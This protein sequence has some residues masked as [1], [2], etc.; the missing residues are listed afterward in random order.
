MSNSDRARRGSRQLAARLWVGIC[1]CCAGIDCDAQAPQV[2]EGFW[3]KSRGPYG[4]C[5]TD[6]IVGRSR[7]L[8]AREDKQFFLRSSDGGA[9]WERLRLPSSS[10]LSHQLILTAE[11]NL[12]SGSGRGVEMSS[13]R[14]NSWT[15]T[16]I[17]Q[18]V[19]ALASLRDGRLLLVSVGLDNR[20]FRSQDGG[21]TWEPFASLP[22]AR[23]FLGHP[24][25]SLLAATGEGVFRSTDEGR[26][27]LFAPGSEGSG[28]LAID[29]R[30]NVFANGKDLLRSRDHG[31]SW[32][33]ILEPEEWIGSIVVDSMDRI[34]VA[35]G[36]FELLR[37]RDGGETWDRVWSGDGVVSPLL[38]TAD[39]RIYVQ[40]CG[41]GGVYQSS[42]GGMTWRQVPLP[43]LY[44]GD[45]VA[46]PAGRVLA[47]TSEGMLRSLDGTRTWSRFFSGRRGGHLFG[48]AHGDVWV[49]G[50]DTLHH[51]ADGGSTWTSTWMSFRAGSNRWLQS[52]AVD[53]RG[54]L[55]AATWECSSD[56]D[57]RLYRSD[58][59]GLSWVETNLGFSGDVAAG[60]AGH[61]VVG[62]EST[63]FVSRD[64][65]VTWS[66]NEQ[67]FGTRSL[68][69]LRVGPGGEV[70]AGT[71]DGLYRSADG[72]DTWIRMPV[73]ALI[74]S[75]AF[76]ANGAVVAAG[77]QGAYLGTP[78]RSSWT[79]I[80]PQSGAAV[81]S[82]AINP[83]GFVYAGIDGQGIVRSREP[84]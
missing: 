67:A 41:E 5:L 27:W 14:G 38:G 13:D 63:V 17:V 48:G 8:Y 71:H 70:M 37:S 44:V 49:A 78:D 9:T 21:H 12:L 25:G 75:I 46:D 59:D 62:E 29:S 57:E 10:P 39:G 83:D 31:A 2:G 26:S 7:E 81:W 73:D 32:E 60:A 53:S 61:V 54:S 79:P 4:G 11:G 58:D 80:G 65:G 43:L 6:L 16:S 77:P 42:D 36:L 35:S 82:V 34:F 18:P 45:L 15:Q 56:C 69:V 28:E 20:V 66:V 40:S 52:M 72:G 23:F 30:G 47:Q 68:W 51:S 50:T 76:A 64:G 3:E 74:R 55:Y 24:D 1:L 22:Q 84:L 19:L 33:V